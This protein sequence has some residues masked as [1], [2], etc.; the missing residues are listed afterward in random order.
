MHKSQIA[1]EQAI[2]VGLSFREAEQ[3]LD[4]KL[5]LNEYPRW[6]IEA[7]HQ[8]VILHEMFLHA[9]EQGQKEAERFI[10]Q[11]HWGSLPRPDPEADQ[12]AMK[13]VGYQTSHKE[14]RDLYHGLYL[15]RRSPGPPPCGPQQRREAIHDILSS[16][17]NHLHRWVYPVAAKEDTWGAVN[18]SQSRLRGREDPHEEALQEARTACQRALEAA[19]VLESDIERLRWGLRDVQ[20]ACPH[21]HSSSCQLSHSWDIRPRSCSRP[22]QERRVT[23]WEPEVEPDSEERPYRGGLGHSS[24]MFLE[25]G[26]RVLLSSQRQENTCPPGRP[27]AYPNAES[28]GN[29]H[30][31]PAIKDV[32]TWLDWWAHQLDMPCWWMELTA[33]PGVEDPRKLPRKC[34]LPF[35]SQQLEAR[36]SWAKG[37]LHPLPP[38]ASPGIC[39]SWTSCPIRTCNSSLFS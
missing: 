3:R 38:S 20:W 29:Y 34:G 22:W 12:S 11:G 36:S 5:F 24:K 35:W 28:R 17:R 37:I 7:P 30:L 13:L 1:G 15:L 23:F 32:E 18:K 39:F 31:E 27:V 26:D 14:I 6:E 10:C 33:I 4:T 16:V 8:S 25:S 9:A 21:S 19:Q 2:E